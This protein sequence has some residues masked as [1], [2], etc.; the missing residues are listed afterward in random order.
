MSLRIEHVCTNHSTFIHFYVVNAVSDA[1]VDKTSSRWW[2]KN[3][4]CCKNRIQLYWN[5]S[6]HPWRFFWCIAKC[7]LHNQLIRKQN[8][9]IFLESRIYFVER[10]HCYFCN[11]ENNLFRSASVSMPISSG[12]V[13]VRNKSEMYSI[14]ICVYNA[15]PFDMYNNIQSYIWGLWIAVDGTHRLW[16]ILFELKWEFWNHEN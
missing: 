15:Y 7:V 5:R 1:N 11:S 12:S 14:V 8:Y 4:I 3:D 16:Q 2:E 10:K 6:S 13:I 9:I